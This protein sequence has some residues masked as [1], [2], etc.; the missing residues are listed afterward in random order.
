MRFRNFMI[1]SLLLGFHESLLCESEQI[2][3]ITG[4]AN[5]MTGITRTD[6][7]YTYL[8]LETTDGLYTLAEGDYAETLVKNMKL[9]SGDIIQANIRVTNKTQRTGS[10]LLKSQTDY[11]Y[12]NG[13]L[14]LLSTSSS[15]EIYNGTRI[16]IKTLVFLVST[17]GWTNPI[18]NPGSYSAYLF[19]NS[20]SFFPG[21]NTIENYYLQCS[22]NKA[23]FLPKNVRILSYEAPCK[24]TMNAGSLTFDF[25]GLSKCDAAELYNWRVTGYN[26]A[27]KQSLTDPD[28]AKFLNVTALRMLVILPSRVAC[29]WAG[30]GSV[31]CSGPSC[32]SYIKGN[33][34]T[35]M[36]IVYHEL[37]HNFG[38]S[39]AGKG[40][41]EYGDRSDEMGSGN[42]YRIV[43]HNVANM[44]RINWAKP[45]I[46]GNLTIYNFT[47]SRNHIKFV[48]PATSIS[49][50]NM[51][52][53]DLNSNLSNSNG[54][55]YPKLFVSYRVAG[56]NYDAGLASDLRKNVFV[57]NF[58]GTQS[59]RDYS[60]SLLLYYGRESKNPVFVG[61]FIP[62]DPI[63]RFGGGV[64]I[65]V[66]STNDTHAVVDVCRMYSLTEGNGADDDACFEGTD[67]D[68]D[69]LYGFDDPDCGA[70]IKP[71]E[72]PSPRPPSPRTP[73]PPSPSKRSPKPRSQPPPKN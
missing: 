11:E 26:I 25:N 36:D 66:L 4:S 23:S 50:K 72:P 12:V 70:I 57:H 64:R 20:S 41:N 3:Q 14:K 58:N 65:K 42:A 67:K 51:V 33:Y 21:R 17:C 48:I 73:S 32:H 10:R 56:P 28:M 59:E 1:L 45:V 44:Y 16:D 71:S 43:C 19:S 38:L 39:H 60:R 7:N 24:G 47:T 35:S 55:K 68:C 54:N 69:D 40:F 53:V 62:Y 49:D 8:N 9:I 6:L 22:Y 61:P 37:Q 52:S 5:V 30:L 13:S 18:Q 46:G 2:A 15:K 34:A 27:K 63:S 31:G 29:G